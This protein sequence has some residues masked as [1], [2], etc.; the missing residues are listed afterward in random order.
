M[1]GLHHA[2]LI[3]AVEISK[4]LV[5][6]RLPLILNDR[7]VDQQIRHTDFGCGNL[8]LHPQN[9]LRSG[10][11]R[12]H[13]NHP[14]AGTPTQLNGKAVCLLLIFMIMQHKVCAAVRECPRH[15]SAEHTGRAGNERDM[16]A[17]VNRQHLI[18]PSGLDPDPISHCNR[19][20]V[21]TAKEHADFQEFSD[22]TEPRPRVRNET[23]ADHRA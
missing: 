21:H 22:K 3:L 4:R 16:A 15:N 10:D 14:S 2:A 1:N 9:I 12:L 19:R 23:R 11:I 6:D 13:R 20:A 5:D 18:T 8:L 17:Q 7:I